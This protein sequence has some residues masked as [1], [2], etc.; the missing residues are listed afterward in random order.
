MSLTLINGSP[1]DTIPA[2]DRGL[3]YGD[4]VFRTLA[5]RAGQVIL[6]RR[7]YDKLS[8]DCLFLL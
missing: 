3:A 7:H 2:D 6:W 5:A 4:G 8:A 1:A